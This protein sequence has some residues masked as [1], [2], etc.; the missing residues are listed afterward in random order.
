MLRKPVNGDGSHRYR[1]YTC[2]P[3]HRSVEVDVPGTTHVDVHDSSTVALTSPEFEIRTYALEAVPSRR[4]R[5][6]QSPIDRGG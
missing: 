3:N 4:R 6:N 1:T 2:G 5:A